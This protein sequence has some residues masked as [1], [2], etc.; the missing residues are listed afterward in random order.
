MSEFGSPQRPKETVI[1]DFSN[2]VHTCW[3][4]AVSAQKADPAKYNARDV[5]LVNMAGKLSTITKDL[6]DRGITEFNLLFVE[7]GTPVQKLKEYPLYKANRQRPTGDEEAPK[8]FAKQWLIEQGYEYWARNDD[9]EADDVIASAAQMLKA[10][11]STTVIVSS[12][13]DLW[14]LIEPGVEVYQITKGRFVT[15]DVIMEEFGVSDPKRVALVKALWGDSGDNVPNA[16]PRMQKQLLPIVN[17]CTSP[18]LES[19]EE[20]VKYGIENGHLTKRCQE[21]LQEGGATIRCNW[22]LVQLDRNLDFVVGQHRPKG[23]NEP[24]AQEAKES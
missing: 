2:F 14:Q 19:F 20:W 16:V 7:D 9:A 24:Q 12:D 18:T 1:I 4:P 22:K 15:P 5:L 6:A 23:Q 8:D 11:K 13:K 21:L 10:R 17:S 3:W